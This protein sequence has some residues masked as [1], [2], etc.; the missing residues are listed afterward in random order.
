MDIQITQGQAIVLYRAVSAN[1]G[2]PMLL[3]RI[4]L[5]CGTW[6]TDHDPDKVDWNLSNK[7]SFIVNPGD[8]AF[9]S[10][11]PV[12]DKVFFTPRHPDGNPFP[13]PANSDRCP[14]VTTQEFDLRKQLRK[15]SL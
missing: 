13:H 4:E 5:L 1:A 10:S 8:V 12:R 11:E 7:Q 3:A 15:L 14:T 2:D 9:L 6:F